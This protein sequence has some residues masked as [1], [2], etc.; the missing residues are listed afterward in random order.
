MKRTSV[1]LDWYFGA[2][3]RHAAT[4]AQEPEEHEEQEQMIQRWEHPNKRAQL[5][6]MLVGVADVADGLVTLLSLGNLLSN[7]EMQ[8]IVLRNR[9]EEKWV[10]WRDA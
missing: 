5:L 8:A 9:N 2:V 6:A 1:I 3:A 10:G 4:L 7:F